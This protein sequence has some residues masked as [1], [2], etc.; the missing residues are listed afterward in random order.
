MEPIKVA[1][2]SLTEGSTSFRNNRLLKKSKKNTSLR[3]K[4]EALLRLAS[5][6]SDDKSSSAS[7]G[8]SNSCP[9][10]S[11]SDAKV[12]LIQMKVQGR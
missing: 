4:A 2:T 8:P 1:K 12:G 6:K 11:T 10:I 5:T 7:G 9:L 3:R